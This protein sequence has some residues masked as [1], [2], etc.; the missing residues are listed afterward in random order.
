MNEL[1]KILTFLDCTGIDEYKWALKNVSF[2]DEIKACE[3]W[4]SDLKK[5]LGYRDLEE[6][7]D[8]NREELLSHDCGG[9]DNGESET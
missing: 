3:Q 4:L 6:L 7:L 1:K 2:D 8:Q 5:L 9:N